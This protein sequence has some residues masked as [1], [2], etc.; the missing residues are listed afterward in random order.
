MDYLSSKLKLFTMLACIGFVVGCSHPLEIEGQGDIVSSTGE[1]NCSIAEQPC[2]NLVVFDYVETYTAVPKAGNQFVGWEGCGDQHPL[3]SYNIPATTVRKQW[4]KTM[5]SLKAVFKLKAPTTP[6]NLVVTE[7]VEQLD[8]SWDPVANAASYSLYYA[9]ES[10][11]SPGN[12]SNYASLANGTRLTGI[13]GTSR[14]LTGL[15]GNTT[16]Y[17]VLV[18]ENATGNS[19]PSGEKSGLTKHPLPSIP[20]NVMVM[21]G[22]ERLDVSWGSVV[23]AVS[24]SVYYA[25]ESFGSPADVV[26]FTNYANGRKVSGITDPSY[27]L[28][29]LTGNT[30]HYVVIVAESGAGSS[31]PSIEKTGLPVQV[32]IP[33]PNAPTGVLITA[34]IEQLDVSWSSVATAT[35]YTLYYATESFGSPASVSNYASLANGTRITGITAT[36]RSLTGLLG[37]TTYYVVL[38]AENGTGSGSPSAEQSGLTEEEPPIRTPANLL[39]NSGLQQ[40]DISWSSVSN[41]THYSLYYATESFGEPVDIV[42]YM[43]YEDAIKVTDITETSYVIED[44]Q[45][46]TTYYVTVVAHNNTNISEPS[47]EVYGGVLFVALNDTGVTFG[48]GYLINATT[49]CVGETIE[50]QDCSHGRDATDNNDNDGDAGFSFT[51]LDTNGD[52]LPAS[53]L[54]WSCVKD[55]VTGLI[56]EVKTTDDGLHNKADTFT[57]YNT[58]YNVNGGYSGRDYFTNAVC[59]GFIDI[60]D[61]EGL[62]NTEAFT[63]R[64]ND[65]QLCG[66]SDW[67][68][69]TVK[70]LAGI[71]NKGKNNPAID[72][73]YFPSTV[74]GDY[75]IYW[76]SNPDVVFIPS[77]EDIGV[78]QKFWAIRFDTGADLTTTIKP[79][80][81]RLVRSNP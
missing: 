51:K 15:Q 39:L 10:F 12:V 77:S 20:T 1:R 56:W 29:G 33:P 17:V 62:C 76:T 23:T 32:P 3:C 41:A 31:E 16:Y 72:T 35:S 57:W 63:A 58:D 6:T 44:A 49:A 5:P 36:S 18:A 47:D 26:N 73:D 28:T 54:E 9:T 7:E 70:E 71:V 81:V 55:N 25:T 21:S 75:S 8:L 64:V 37:N 24:Y 48:E 66:Y 68:L 59:E 80:S 34:G 40:L 79:Y 78:T 60:D 61:S 38:V 4:F 74:S 19:A 45:Y 11:G 30:T 50:A 69:P 27:S 22:I 13:T 42:N 67:R 14:L 52:D 65:T 2:D 43:A 53:E 46:H